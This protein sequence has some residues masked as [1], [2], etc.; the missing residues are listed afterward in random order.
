M[1]AL[2][3]QIQKNQKTNRAHIERVIEQD[4]IRLSRMKKKVATSK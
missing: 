4:N 1:K 2:K 3:R